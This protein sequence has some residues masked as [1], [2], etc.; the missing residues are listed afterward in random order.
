MNLSPVNGKVGFAL[1]LNR[2][3]RPPFLHAAGSPSGQ[4]GE[5]SQKDGW[6]LELSR[7]YP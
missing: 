5:A 7:E 6:G 3:S 1:T 2:Q 4:V